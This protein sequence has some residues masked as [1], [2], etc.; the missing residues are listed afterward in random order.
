MASVG[1]I[2]LEKEI[3]LESGT[4]ELELLVFSVSNCVFGINVAKVREVLPAQKITRVPQSHPSVVGSFQLRNSIVSC[5]SLHQHLG[6]TEMNRADQHTIIVTEI[7][8]RQTAYFVDRVENIHRISWE[9]VLSPPAILSSVNSPV[10]AVTTIGE[11]LILL[12]DLELVDAQVSGVELETKTHENTRNLPRHTLKIVLADDSSTVR[13]GITRTLSSSGYTDLT[14]ANNGEEAWLILEN[15]VRENLCLPD[16]II[17]DVEM[18]RIDG[19]H[20]TKRIKNHNQLKHIPVLLYSSIVSPDNQK[21]GSAVGADAQV[22]KPDLDQIVRIAD[23][24]I[25]KS[26]P[27]SESTDHS[28]KINGP[29]DQ[30]ECNQALPQ[31]EPA[32]GPNRTLETATLLAAEKADLPTS[33]MLDDAHLW[34]T[35]QREMHQRVDHLDALCKHYNQQLPT[36]DATNDLLRTLHSIKSAADVVTARPVTR[37]AHWLEDQ[38]ELTTRNGEPWPLAELNQYVKWLRDLTQMPYPDS[39]Q[40]IPEFSLCVSA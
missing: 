28:A 17:S 38:L 18:P 9:E 8:Q 7:N 39:L 15:M 21:K 27:F 31:V 26:Q 14:M 1:N 20:L 40:G 34:F 33:E 6:L 24:L 10:T 13:E 19:F 32:H 3:L 36:D 2:L 16:L 5:V 11:R 12:L 4:N 25:S 35:F 37:S 29:I 22:A 23:D 30:V